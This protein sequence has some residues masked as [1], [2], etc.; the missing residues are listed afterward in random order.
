MKCP[1]CKTQTKTRVKETR[2][3]NGDIVRRREC[4]A[5]GHNFGTK[6]KIDP[7]SPI[8]LGSGNNPHSAVMP[9]WKPLTDAWGRK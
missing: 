1:S 9:S 3:V 6:E 2:L 4:E 5:C 8:N 7:K